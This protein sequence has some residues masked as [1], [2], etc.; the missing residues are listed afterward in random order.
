MLNDPFVALV[1]AILTIKFKNK[2]EKS[3][4]TEK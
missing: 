4:I 1:Y 2:I 3:I